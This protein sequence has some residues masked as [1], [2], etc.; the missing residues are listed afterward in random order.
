[1]VILALSSGERYVA[2]AYIAFLVLILI[3][4]AIMATKLARLE[5]EVVE[6]TQIAERE[7]APEERAREAVT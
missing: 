4:L 5:R 7:P 1:M 3:Y 6:L 2:G